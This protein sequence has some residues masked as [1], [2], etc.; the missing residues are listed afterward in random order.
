MNS[1]KRLLLIIIASASSVFAQD[2][3]TWDANGFLFSR[4]DFNADGRHDMVI[5]DTQ[6]G[7]IRLV[8]QQVSGAFTWGDVQPSGIEQP[9]ALSVGKFY[10]PSNDAIAVGSSTA[11]RIHLF[12]ITNPAEIFTP[13]VIYP[14]ATGPSSLAAF[15]VDATGTADM[16]AICEGLAP[17]TNKGFGRVYD[18]IVSLT[19]TPTVSWTRNFNAPTYRVNPVRP[20]TGSAPRIAEIYGEN[21][22]QFYLEVVGAAGLSNSISTS[23]ITSAMR[24]SVGSLDATGLT[25]VMFWTPDQNSL[26]TVRINEPTAGNF[27]F[28]TPVIYTL[29]AGIRLVL[30]IQTGAGARIAVLFSNGTVRVYDFDG[31]GIPV[32]RWSLTSFPGDLLLPVGTNDFLVASG[33]RGDT[34]QWRRYAPLSNS[35]A[36]TQSGNAPVAGD[37]RRY[38]NI[39]FLSSEPFVNAGVEPKL[40]SQF[41]EW[42][43]SATPGNG[44]AWD[45]QSLAYNGSNSGLGSSQTTTLSGT[46]ITDF[47]LLNQYT[48]ALSL[49]SMEQKTGSHLCD[50]LFSPPPGTYAAP[51]TAPTVP[52]APAAAV[53]PNLQVSVATTEAG[54]ALRYRTSPAADYAFVPANGIIDLSATTTLQVYASKT[55]ERSPVRS[56]TYTIA[57][58]SSLA[59][60]SSADADLD[61]LPDAW[62]SAFQVSDPQADE[63]LDGYSNLEEA[64]YGGDPGVFAAIAAIDPRISG[65]MVNGA[66]NSKI[67]RLEWPAGDTLSVLESTTNFQSWLAVISPSNVVGNKRRVDISI[68]PLEIKRFFRLRRP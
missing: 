12:G 29:P 5:V 19:S 62:E 37:S 20:K 53:L 14:N 38:S 67:I 50:I 31:A 40:F 4:G 25:H 47:P 56:A 45:I 26:R 2:P 66:G 17:L 15:D 43:V 65:V 44:L 46:A 34:P 54:F 57:A 41:R 32:E 23:G 16:V 28:G 10:S 63:D 21:S 33:L 36:L 13:A 8:N 30:P 3:F 49:F 51:A 61:G 1:M 27:V 48:N 64:Q 18:A 42:T 7:G 9:E 22:A 58:A 60:P 24:Y 39:L 35:Y 68:N 11:N 52:G 6:T 59:L 55:G